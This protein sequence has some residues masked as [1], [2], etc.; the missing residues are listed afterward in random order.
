MTK[1]IIDIEGEFNKV[2]KDIGG[3]L[4]INRL[5]QESPNFENADYVFEKENVI[6]ELK[7]LQKNYSEDEETQKKIQAK[8]DKWM[9]ESKRAF[10]GKSMVVQSDALPK[11]L[12]WELSRIYSEPVRRAIK[13][14]NR[15]I[16]ETKKHLKMHEALGMVLIVNDG[17][18]SLKPEHFAFAAHQS[19]TADF[20]SI[21][22][23]SLVTV[24][25]NAIKS[26]SHAVHKLWFY[27]ERNSL[28]KINPRFLLHL[29]NAWIKNYCHIT[30][31]SF[32]VLKEEMKDISSLKFIKEDQ[33]KS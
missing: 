15:Q 12:Q 32:P 10:Y 2:I 33:K 29:R 1:H 24:N 8:F 9:N 11:K 27:Y 18:Y 28:V 4:V 31:E 7:I 14:A 21:H 19:L 17:N 25:M 22:G 3:D 16:R 20:S 6:I 5:P 30:G 13:K 23:A 26:G